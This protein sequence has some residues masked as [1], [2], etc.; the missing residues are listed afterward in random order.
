MF[1]LGIHDHSSG[2]LL[3]LAVSAFV[4]A[5]ARGFSGFGSALIFVPLASTPSDP[6]SPRISC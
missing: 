6:R 2:A 4:A 1:D 3:L 5:L